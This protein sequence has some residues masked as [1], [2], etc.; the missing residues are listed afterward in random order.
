MR[1]IS[2]I[3]AALTI[4]ATLISGC[5]DTQQ[6]P[7]DTPPPSTQ[8]VLKGSSLE[9]KS[10]GELERNFWGFDHGVKVTSFSTNSVTDIVLEKSSELGEEAVSNSFIVA[11]VFFCEPVQAYV[12]AVDGTKTN[13]KIT[14]PS[15]ETWKAKQMKSPICN[16]Q[17]P[18]TNVSMK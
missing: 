12:Y 11:A 17:P 13:D 1:K 3:S 2:S 15:F 7:P 4:S 14:S 9:G 10:V 18:A 5:S 8:N 16:G 6:T